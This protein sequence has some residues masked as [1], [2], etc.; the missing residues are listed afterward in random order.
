M[1]D[2]GLDPN[3]VMVGLVVGIPSTIA[4]FGSL[5]ARREAAGANR[6]VNHKVKGSSTI[7]EQVDAIDERTKVLAYDFQTL[8]SDATHTRTVMTAVRSE[9]SDLR[10]RLDRHLAHTEED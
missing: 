10:A 8:K 4:A 1:S 7:S 6:A 9:V 5:A 3:M 2:A